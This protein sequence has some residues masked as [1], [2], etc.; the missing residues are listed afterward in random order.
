VDVWAL[1]VL[2]YFLLSG[3]SPFHGNNKTKDVQIRNARFVF[4]PSD[5]WRPVSSEAK[6]FIALCL[7]RDPEKRP[8]AEKA[9]SLPWMKLGLEIMEEYAGLQNGNGN[10]TSRKLSLRDPALPSA[11]S[12]LAAMDRMNHLNAVEKAGIIATAHYLPVETLA[13]LRHQFERLDKNKEGL[14][15]LQELFEVLV[16]AGV[17]CQDLLKQVTELDREGMVAA[18][19]S[20]FVASALDFQHNMQDNAVGAVFRSFDIPDGR[21]HASKKDVCKVLR[22][23]QENVRQCL[24]N[25]FPG[26]RLERVISDL[27][28]DGQNGISFDE[29]CKVLRQATVPQ[30]EGNT[31][32]LH[33][34]QNSINTI[35]L[36]RLQYPKVISA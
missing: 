10:G 20:E 16:K 22:E 9:L 1:G 32:R 14:L 24:S 19:Y 27:E 28:Q 35:T 30:V 36:Q 3:Q 5:L 17:P 33:T 7:Q 13:N 15:S 11:Q 31:P 26:L 23:S 34:S 2:A 21:N 18:D 12:I 8:T 29:F 25:T 6:H 4:M